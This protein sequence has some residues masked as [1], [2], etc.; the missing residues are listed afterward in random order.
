MRKLRNVVLVVLLVFGIFA[1]PSQVLAET[2]QE[3]N[4][5][6][7]GKFQS[8]FELI[9]YWRENGFPDK[10]A[11]AY[12]KV[13][14]ENN[15]WVAVVDGDAKTIQE[16]MD[17]VED[18]SGLHFVSAEYSYNELLEV[19]E[20][21][22]TEY[23][24]SYTSISIDESDNVVDVDFYTKAENYR[25]AAKAVQD[26]YGNMIRVDYSDSLAQ[27]LPAEVT[28][29]TPKNENTNMVYGSVL[30]VLAIGILG[31]SIWGDY[32]NKKDGIK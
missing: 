31:M 21:I 20:Y 15:L 3:D 32:G 16:I 27:N 24:L 11:G 9:G 12:G 19:I 5:T 26:K 7:E 6:S 8:C 18:D 2:N 1:I 29:E 10:V 23:P 22:N 25:Q 30:G 17:M 14:S 28:K 13:D 4:K